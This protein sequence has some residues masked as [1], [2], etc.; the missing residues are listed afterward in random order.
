MEIIKTPIGFRTEYISNDDKKWATQ[1]QCEQYE[2]LLEDPTPLK[3]LSFFDRKGNPLDIFALEEIPP[4]SYLVLKKD[5]EHYDPEVV[6]KIIGSKSATT[7]DY[8]LP[9][10]RGIWFN[11]WSS[12]YNGGYGVNGWKECETIKTL[13]NT[14]KRCQEKIELFQKIGVDK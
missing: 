8:E 13:Q 7:S 4:F 1:K 14:I 6:K 2:Q 12:A 5:I 3:E 10:T 11:D 9:T